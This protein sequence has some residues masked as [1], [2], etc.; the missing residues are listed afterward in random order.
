M[1]VRSALPQRIISL[2][3][4]LGLT[5]AFTTMPPYTAVA[6]QAVPAIQEAEDAVLDDEGLP[7]LPESPIE[8]A[9]REENVI[10]LSL[11]EVTKMAL[12]NN[13]DI[14]IEDT[15]EETQRWNLI[16]AE[17]SYD[18]SLSGR[19]SLQSSRR[20]NTLSYEES[21]GDFITSKNLNWS[22]SFSQ[23]VKTG[24]TFSASYSGSRV[25]SDSSA[26]NFN[27]EY[28]AQGSIEFTQ[29]LWKNLTIDQN[30]G[31][32]KIRKLDMDT[33]DINFRQTVITRISQIKQAQEHK[34][35]ATLIC[36]FMTSS[37][38]TIT[39]I[40]FQELNFR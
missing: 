29:P 1:K 9:E 35:S 24:G 17:A 27:P 36:P 3:G 39:M 40:L 32:I 11:K 31:Q 14:A 23:P 30:R 26:R 25:S 19:F 12:Q 21:E 15:N 13:I 28:S 38:I 4:I 10:Y 22:T 16:S 20:A 8:K 33:S 7:P 37:S 5:L 18:P 34:D 6:Q 2:L